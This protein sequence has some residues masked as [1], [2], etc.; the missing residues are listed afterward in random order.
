MKK[1]IVVLS[2]IMIF[3]SLVAMAAGCRQQPEPVPLT[4]SPPTPAPTPP[5]PV[6]PPTPP[7]P[8]PVTDEPEFSENDE[9]VSSQLLTQVN[10]RKEQIADPTSDRLKLMKNMGMRVDNLEIQRIFIHLSQELNT[11]QIEELESMGIVLY[12]D[13]WIPPVGAHPTGFILADMPI[14]RLEELAGKDYI[15]RLET[16]EQMLEPTNG[17]QPQVE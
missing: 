7:T 2:I 10:L 8:S 3:L 16:A 6:P 13:S 9:K 17:S 11:S 15:V 1:T 5:T 14:D 12:L 4:P